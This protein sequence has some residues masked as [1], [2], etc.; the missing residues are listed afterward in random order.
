MTSSSMGPH[1]TIIGNNY[2]GTVPGTLLLTMNE[3]GSLSYSD[4]RMLNSA[5]DGIG[6]SFG[7]NT[8]GGPGV[9]GSTFGGG[10]NLGNLN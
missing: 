1:P 9:P 4:P 2:T 3:N 5:N 10:S 8:V 6:N 7:N